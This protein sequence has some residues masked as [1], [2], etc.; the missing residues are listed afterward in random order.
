VHL[1]RISAIEGRRPEM[2]ELIDRVLR[3]SPDADQALALR[4]LRAYATRDEAAI[5]QV[6]AELQQARALTVGIAFADVALYS[7]DLAGAERLGRGFIQAARSPELRALCHVLLAHLALA[8]GRPETMGAELVEAERLDPTWGLEM[9][10]YFAT[11]PFVP[12]AQGELRDV[13]DALERWNPAAAV[14]SLSPIFALHN[15]LHPAIRTYLLGLL[16]VRLGD[17]A[18]AAVRLEA[19]TELEASG[20]V[21]RNLTVELDAAIAHAAGRAADALARLEQSRPELW[22]QLTV[23]SPFFSLASQRFLRARLL[24][25]TGRLEEAAGWYRTIAQRSPYEL[26]YDAPARERLAAMAGAAAALTR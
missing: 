18:A 10:A 24:E 19:L 2:L 22:F 20:T 26:I 15:D 8:M 6:T 23:A 7:G 16:E 1:V 21:V 14:P 4:A 17:A 5:A 9:R 25:E 11:L 13:R 3:T 12:T